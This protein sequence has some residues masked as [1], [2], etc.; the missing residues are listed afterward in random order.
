MV[1]IQILYDQG[2][3]PIPEDGIIFQPPHYFG[4]VDGVSGIYL[5]HEGPKLFNGKT[6]GQFASCAISCAFGT[7]LAGESLEDILL[8]ANNMIQEVSEARGLSLSEPELLP[9]ASFAV[10]SID[11]Q[12][13]TILQGGDCLTIWQ[14][15]DRAIGGTPNQAFTF[16]RGLLGTITELMER[17]KG[18][19]QKMWEEFRP[20]LTEKRRANF[21]TAQGGFAILNGQPEVEHFWQKFTLQREK[22]ALLI[23]FS[24]GFVPFE[25]TRDEITMGEKVVRLYRKGGLHSVLK[26]TRAVQEQEK[27]SS[28][29]DYAEATAIVIEL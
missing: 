28:H 13:I 8:R 24:D 3:A 23:L 12:E 4:T 11:T 7:A 27:S 29:E 21:N 18:D 15:R 2:S 17:H 10:A 26:V 5:P 22:T 1:R 16:V 9:S 20:I 19:R 25:W 6:G 14:M